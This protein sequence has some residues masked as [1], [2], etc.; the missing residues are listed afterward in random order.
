[1]GGAGGTGAAMRERER[2][3]DIQTDN[4]TDIQGPGGSGGMKGACGGGGG[5][6]GGA[7]GGGRAGRGT[8]TVGSSSKVMLFSLR[9]FSSCIT[10]SLTCRWRGQ[11]LKG[12]W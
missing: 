7:G 12:V 4:Q 2:W 3:K 1:M 10:R 8:C 5:G 9:R 6:R 11:V